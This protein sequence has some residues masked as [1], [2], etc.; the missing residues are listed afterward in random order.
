MVY[1]IGAKKKYGISLDLVFNYGL[2]KLSEDKFITQI[3]KTNETYTNYVTRRGN[4]IAG[5]IGFIRIFQ[6]S[7]KKVKHTKVK[8][9]KVR[10]F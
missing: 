5:N 2:K 9:P 10:Y 7:K 3:Y 8:R 6:D 4:Y 1:T